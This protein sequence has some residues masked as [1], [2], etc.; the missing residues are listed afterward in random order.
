MAR[1][2]TGFR[3]GGLHTLL[4]PLTRPACPACTPPRHYPGW[5]PQHHRTT[6][7]PPTVP[8]AAPPDSERLAGFVLQVGDVGVTR[9]CLVDVI[10]H[11]VDDLVN[12]S[13]GLQQRGLG[14]GR[15]AGVGRGGRGRR[16]SVRRKIDP[17]LFYYRTLRY[18]FSGFGHQK[19]R[20]SAPTPI[21]YMDIEPRRS[22]GTT[23]P[24]MPQ[25][26]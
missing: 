26:A 7:L 12:F 23:P 6:A 9:Q 8:T 25:G 13:L 16:I 21:W 19:N 10:P 24:T 5:A 14:V 3:E 15:P 1:C 11:D 22:P 2:G 4:A 20:S 18:S 17:K